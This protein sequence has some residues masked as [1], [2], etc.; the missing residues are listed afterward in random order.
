MTVPSARSPLGARSMKATICV[1]ALTAALTSAANAST[2]PGLYDTGVTGTAPGTAPLDP[3]LNDTTNN[4]L[5]SHFATNPG[6]A[7]YTFYTP[8]YYSESLSSPAEWIS[9]ATAAVGGPNF[10]TGVG[11]YNYT[12]TFSLAG[13]TPGSAVISGMWAADNCAE[14]FV[15]GAATGQIIGGGISGST[16]NSASSNFTSLHS[17]LINSGDATFN[18]GINTLDFEVYN[19]SLSTALLVTDLQANAVP[20][21]SP[22]LLTLTG[23][24]L[25]GI[26][27]QRRRVPFR[28]C[29]WHR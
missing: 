10:E 13:L 5:D 17:F 15:N 1:L 18:A 23:F 21:P 24:V 20:E 6:T 4:I 26:T 8:P 2:I 7:A 14:I 12:E 11:I 16:C 19:S 9:T 28:R 25:L 29:L 27:I 22:V 3:T